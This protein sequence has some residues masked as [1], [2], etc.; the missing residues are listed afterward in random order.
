MCTISSRE[1]LLNQELL[2][3]TLEETAPNICFSR[4]PIYFM[5]LNLVIGKNPVTVAGTVFGVMCR[6]KSTRISF[7][8]VC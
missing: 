4:K 7:R 2:Y 1:Q 5:F 8:F 3:K 6:Y